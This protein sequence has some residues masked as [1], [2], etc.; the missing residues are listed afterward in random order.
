MKSG[1]KILAILFCML[2]CAGG[3]MLARKENTKS[4]EPKTQ[5]A[6]VINQEPKRLIW[7]LV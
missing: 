3:A 6:P 2:L 4:A 1:T 5:V 7:I